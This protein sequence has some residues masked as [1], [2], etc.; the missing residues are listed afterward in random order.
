MFSRKQ[1]EVLQ[2]LPLFQAIALDQPNVCSGNNK[3]LS[4]LQQMLQTL[5]FQKAVFSK[6]EHHS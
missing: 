1:D 5:V 3:H 6:G 2:T 4:V